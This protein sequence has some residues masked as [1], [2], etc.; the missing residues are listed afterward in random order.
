MQCMRNFC[1]NPI[2]LYQAR[3]A[4]AKPGSDMLRPLLSRRLTLTPAR[5]AVAARRSLCSTVREA[6][7][8][9]VIFSAAPAGFEEVI[10]IESG[11]GTDQHGQD[12]TK[13]SVRACKDA[14][15]FNSIP[16]L[17]KLVPE[18]RSAMLKIQ[19]A[20]PFD[21]DDQPPTI[22]L[23]AVR[24]CFPYG[25]VL[26]IELVR[27][28]ARFGSLCS[29]PSLGDADASDSWVFAIACVTVGY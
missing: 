14:I 22:D 9:E 6:P 20:V 8:I 4:L 26:P 1:E 23:D 18:G 21:A 25:R 2:C 12:L 10:M 7:K 28:G 13:A 11:V 24:E 29:V 27:G 3:T 17:G 5:M 15:S 19:L 16:S